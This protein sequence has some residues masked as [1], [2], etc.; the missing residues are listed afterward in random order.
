MRIS[1]GL[2]LTQRLDLSASDLETSLGVGTH[3]GDLTSLDLHAIGVGPSE[4]GFLGRFSE[5]DATLGDDAT[6]DGIQRLV[7]TD[8]VH[9]AV[10]GVGAG[11]GVGEQFPTT[12][13][14]LG[15]GLAVG[16]GLGGGFF[17]HGYLVV[18]Y[19]WVGKE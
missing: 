10:G 3:D 5:R 18:G 12:T 1:H 13:T 11:R 19:W 6:H 9:H 17:F 16:A 4:Q 2:G 15:R 8:M 14:T 7:D